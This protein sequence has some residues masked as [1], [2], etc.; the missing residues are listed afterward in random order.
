MSI[1]IWMR[2]IGCPLFESGSDIDLLVVNFQ[3]L[4]P[5]FIAQDCISA[6]ALL[7]LRD[8]YLIPHFVQPY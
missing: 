4:I 8:R 7:K 5:Q 6:N 2:L 1:A 3:G